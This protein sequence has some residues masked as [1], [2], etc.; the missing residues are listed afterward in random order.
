MKKLLFLFSALFFI[1]SA[2]I[3]AQKV[4]ST[5]S[6]EMIFSSGTLEFTDAFKS[7]NPQA[8]ISDTPV[9]FTTFYHVTQLWHLDFGENIGMYTGL[10]IRN[11]GMISNEML[12]TGASGMEAVQPYKIIRRL[13]TGGIPLAMKL[14]AF[15]QNLY[16]YGGGEIEFGIHYKEKYWNSHDRSGSKTK[17]KAWFASQTNNILPS[18]FA[19]VQLPG[20]ANVKFRYYLTDFLN[21][22][23]TDTNPVSD[24]TRY[25]SSQLWY[26]SLSWNINTAYLTKGEG[27]LATR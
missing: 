27:S 17:T 9:R 13:Y 10:G 21:H 2:K 20:G 22:N 1:F 25:K 24:L 4:Y 8:Q 12:N 19:G 18:V 14:G 23:Y 7:Q 6:G 5:T 15:D 11:V 3:N 26:V 16:V